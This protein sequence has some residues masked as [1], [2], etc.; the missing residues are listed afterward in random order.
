MPLKVP[1]DATMPGCEP[2]L[3]PEIF[4]CDKKEKL[5]ITNKRQSKVVQK[6]DMKI[7]KA[8]KTILD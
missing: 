6:K 5:K 7:I 4:I 8:W 1:F 3:L 2:D